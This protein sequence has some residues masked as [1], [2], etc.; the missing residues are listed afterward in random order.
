M[1]EITVNAVAKPADSFVIVQKSSLNRLLS[2]ACCPTC[3]QS[4]T[5]FSLV[6]GKEVGFAV[7]GRLFCGLCEQSFQKPF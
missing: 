6:D 1:M 7:K 4:G 5:T 2:F 3:K